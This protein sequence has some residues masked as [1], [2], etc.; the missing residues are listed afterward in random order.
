VKAQVCARVERQREEPGY[1]QANGWFRQSQG[2]S[3]QAVACRAGVNC[4]GRCL[5]PEMKFDAS[6]SA[7]PAGGHIGQSRQQLAQQRLDLDAGDVRAE[8]EVRSATTERDLVVRRAS[9][10]E[11]VGLDEGA[12]RRGW[13]SRST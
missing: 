4:T 7:G 2:P 5:G 13:R 3:G 9:D 8:A 10:V 12:A 11:A 6:H 1:P